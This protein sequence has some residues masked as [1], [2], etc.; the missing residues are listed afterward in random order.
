MLDNVG[1]E[2]YSANNFEATVNRAGKIPKSGAGVRAC[3][4]NPSPVEREKVAEGRMRVVGKNKFR[5][6]ASWET[7]TGTVL[8]PAQFIL[9]GISFNCSA[10][11]SE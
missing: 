7:R 2:S 11:T 6:A 9:V 3:G 5:P 1:P 4:F 8:E 10:T